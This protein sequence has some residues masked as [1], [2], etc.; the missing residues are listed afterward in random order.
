LWLSIFVP[1]VLNG[2]YNWSDLQYFFPGVGVILVATVIG[3]IVWWIIWR[4]IT[5]RQGYLIDVLRERPG[6]YL[7]VTN[8]ILFGLVWCAGALGLA[9]GLGE[10]YHPDAYARSLVPTA[11]VMFGVVGVVFVFSLLWW[12][13]YHSAT[14]KR[15]LLLG[16]I[17][18]VL[19]GLSGVVTYVSTEEKPA[20][21]TYEFLN[22]MYEIPREYSPS[23][24]TNKISGKV[25]LSI[26]VCGKAPLMGEYDRLAKQVIEGSCEQ[27]T[28]M[29]QPLINGLPSYLD[30]TLYMFFK[31]GQ[32]GFTVATSTDGVFLNPINSDDLDS[33]RIE[34]VTKDNMTII[35]TRDGGLHN[36]NYHLE[37]VNNKLQWVT[38]CSLWY[39]QNHAAYPDEFGYWLRA[40][41]YNRVQYDRG[42]LTE[43]E[44][45][46]YKRLHED[47]YEL[48]NSFIVEE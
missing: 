20:T 12:F 25:M 45:V 18:V 2:T 29:I 10:S 34:V 4:Q 37:F 33:T 9:F 36:D 23:F 15:C 5:H 16:A 44:I 21:R 1:Y 35:T 14:P 19:A 32:H 22:N 8:V 43:Q 17:A 26:D 11:G 24:Y 31:D 3:T 41:V 39:C 30:F 13:K 7:L 48:F 46:E 28:H 38:V 40:D 6:L 42:Y 47:V 27:G